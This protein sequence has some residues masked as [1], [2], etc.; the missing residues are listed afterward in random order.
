MTLLLTHFDCL[1]LETACSC[2]NMSVVSIFCL[3]CWCRFS[4]FW[5]QARFSLWDWTSR[6]SSP[7]AACY[8]SEM[9]SAARENE[10][11]TNNMH[12]SNLHGLLAL[13]IHD[14]HKE[15]MII[16]EIQAASIWMESGCPE[17]FA[18]FFLVHARYRT[19]LPKESTTL[20]TWWSHEKIA[21]IHRRTLRTWSVA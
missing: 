13:W 8:Q 15:R 14:Q 20:T 19:L 9:T 18:G 21:N 17:A 10:T 16:W 3:H 12:I 6:D 11:E 7:T 1:H 2:D 5:T 4:R